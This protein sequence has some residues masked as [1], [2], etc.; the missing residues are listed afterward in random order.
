MI[1]TSQKIVAETDDKVH[2]QKCRLWHAQKVRG[3]PSGLAAD[4]VQYHQLP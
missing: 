1:M 4:H 2:T 3:S